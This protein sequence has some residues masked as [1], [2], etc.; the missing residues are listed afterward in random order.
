MDTGRVGAG[1]G[2]C[3]GIGDGGANAG[4][5]GRR[6]LRSKAIAAAI[7]LAGIG[8]S[9]GLMAWS[10][11]F[12]PV[13]L[14]HS[15]YGFASC[16]LNPALAALTLS[17]IT[18]AAVAER[19]GR[20]ARYAAVGSV[21]GAILMGMCGTWVS[22]QA[23]FWLAAL[24]CVPALIALRSLGR[25]IQ[26]PLPSATP[27]RL[28]V[29][30]TVLSVLS[31]RRLL[32]Y[33]ACAILFHLANAA[34][35]PLAGVEITKRADELA[36]L[37]IAAC[38]LVPQLVVAL[39]SPMVGRTAQ[40]RGRRCVLLVGFCALPLRAALLTVV[41]D[42]LWIVPVQALDGLAGAAFGVITPLVVADIAGHNG[43]FS[44]RMGILG[45]SIGGPRQLVTSWQ[46]RSQ[47]VWAPR[48]HSLCL[49]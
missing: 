15:V 27:D 30:E 22:T 34:I 25:R 4:W 23:V 48:R 24:L 14:A 39:L 16:M 31:D 40:R 38:I 18:G 29:G 45:L 33:I 9:A 21:V 12:W 44:L 13:L 41:T 3:V 47:P 28:V 5:T 42:P 2:G 6:R 20:N 46:E 19:L 43:R 36:S 1:I 35:L 8:T 11:E 26:K 37:I 10:P 32:A 7:A 17:F 49:R